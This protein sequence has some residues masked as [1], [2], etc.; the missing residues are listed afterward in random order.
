MQATVDERVYPDRTCG[1]WE[2]GW[3]VFH[4]RDH[5]REWF[6]SET[7]QVYAIGTDESI[8]VCRN[9]QIE[10]ERRDG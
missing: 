5:D 8:G 10:S 1:Q 2:A 9:V 3:V 4:P 7:G 6:L